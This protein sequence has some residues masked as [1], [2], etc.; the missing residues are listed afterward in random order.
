MIVSSVIVDNTYA[1]LS[2]KGRR[3]VAAF[4]HEEFPLS[5]TS[6]INIT[7]SRGWDFVVPGPLN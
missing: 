1:T 3:G 2:L 5:V 6:L 7:V 4:D